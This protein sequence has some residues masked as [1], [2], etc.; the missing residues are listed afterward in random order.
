MTRFFL[1]FSSVMQKGISTVC[2]R[3][4]FTRVGLVGGGNSGTVGDRFPLVCEFLS[5]LCGFPFP[6]TGK[7]CENGAFGR[8]EG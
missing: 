1:F 7:L 6:P 2:S 4:S 3:D 5:D 8:V